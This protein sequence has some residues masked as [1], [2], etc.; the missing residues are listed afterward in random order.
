MWPHTRTAFLMAYYNSITWRKPL[1]DGS[2]SGCLELCLQVPG[3]SRFRVS[4]VAVF[5]QWISSLI[6]HKGHQAASNVKIPIYWC[7]WLWVLMSRMWSH[8]NC[9]CVVCFSLWTHFLPRW[10]H[11]GTMNARRPFPGT[12]LSSFLWLASLT[13]KEP[14]NSII[15]MR[16]TILHSF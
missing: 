5:L 16:W 11:T 14:W 10:T 3:T 13:I 15:L 1:S 6:W 7:H 12:L 2:I 8:S 9:Q 4:T